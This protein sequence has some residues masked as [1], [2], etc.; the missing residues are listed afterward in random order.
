MLSFIN[1]WLSSWSH[2]QEVSTHKSVN[3]LLM[4]SFFYPKYTYIHSECTNSYCY[5]VSIVQSI[6]CAAYFP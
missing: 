1:A 5:L 6:D 4:T 2:S 3:D